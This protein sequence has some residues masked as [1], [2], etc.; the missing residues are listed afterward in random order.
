MLYLFHDG[1]NT[2]IY[3]ELVLSKISVSNLS[4]NF[5][6]VKFVFYY[7][8]SEESEKQQYHPKSDF[9][10]KILFPKIMLFAFELQKENI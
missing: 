2:D 7:G 3:S 8:Q 4:W 5:S 10:A 9:V 6:S 1:K